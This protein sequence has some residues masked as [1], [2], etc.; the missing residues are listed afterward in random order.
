MIKYIHQTRTS[1]RALRYLCDSVG[2]VLLYVSVLLMSIWAKQAYANTV[3]Y[4][5]NIQL[6]PA[7]C[8]LNPALQK[9]RQCLEGYPLIVTGLYPVV[10]PRRNCSTNSAVNLPPLQARAISRI[11]PNERDRQRLWHDIGGCVDADA[12][13]YFRLMMILAER[14][15]IPKILKSDRAYQIQSQQLKQQILQLNPN[16]PSD[17]V[18]LRC[19]HDNRRSRS[20]LTEIRLCYKADGRYHACSSL[21]QSTCPSTIVIEGAY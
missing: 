5:M 15:T 6:A 14:F 7:V 18:H 4:M 10:K 1:H 2:I 9:Q 19:H 21:T 12:N 11:M 8:A 13:Q 3:G 20:V 17:A 16:I